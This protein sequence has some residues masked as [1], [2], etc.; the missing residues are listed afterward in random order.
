MASIEE[1]VSSVEHSVQQLAASVQELIEEMRR[2][3]EEMR[4]DREEMRRDREEMRRDREEMRRRW[5]EV[6]NRLGTLVEDVV[7]PNIPRIAREYFNC[8][9]LDFFAIRVKRR[10]PSDKSRQREFD[11][12]AAGD[13][14]VFVVEAKSSPRT[15][16]VDVFATFIRSGEFFE[17]FPEYRGRKIIPIFAAF[18]L[19][20]SLV[21]YLT[22]KGIYA[23]AM[24]EETMTLLN[25][26]TLK[27]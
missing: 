19:D 26:D 8:S 12:I 9:D 21:N 3:R 4:R 2:D 22:K 27:R 5:G 7:A 1:R 25:A 6:V 14:L 16:D 10:P 24:G 11:V 23:L 15:R 20:E 17:Y 18:Y 13:D